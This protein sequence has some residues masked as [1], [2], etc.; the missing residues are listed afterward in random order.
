MYITFFA[1]CTAGAG[2]GILFH[3]WW[4][5]PDIAIMQEHIK[6]LEDQRARLSKIVTKDFKVTMHSKDKNGQLK[7]NHV[8]GD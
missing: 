4:I 6:K 8:D 5:K 7:E 3:R 2:F 1:G